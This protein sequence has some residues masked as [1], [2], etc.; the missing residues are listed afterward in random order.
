MR[1]MLAVGENRLAAW[2]VLRMKEKYGRKA[3]PRMQDLTAGIQRVCCNLRLAEKTRFNGRSGII[4]T[5]KKSL[6]INASTYQS[7]LIDGTKEGAASLGWHQTRGRTLLRVSRLA[8][9]FT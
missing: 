6:T 3:S 8:V 1:A 4:R 9:K 5:G 2:T 7:R